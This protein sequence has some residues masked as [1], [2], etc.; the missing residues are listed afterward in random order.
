MTEA[1]ARRVRLYLRH[2]PAWR[3][4]AELDPAAAQAVAAMPDLEPMQ[5]CSLMV[6]EVLADVI[7]RVAGPDAEAK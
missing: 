4:Y 7:K 5:R 2:S 6:R 3:A 1:H